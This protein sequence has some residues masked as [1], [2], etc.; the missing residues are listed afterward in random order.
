[1]GCLVVDTPN[2]AGYGARVRKVNGGKKYVTVTVLVA[3][4]RSAQARA[5][6]NDYQR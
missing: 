1:M 5:I 4:R 6:H 2:A 3:R